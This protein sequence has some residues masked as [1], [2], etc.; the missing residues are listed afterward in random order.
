LEPDLS[1]MVIRWLSS[2]VLFFVRIE[3]SRWSPQD[4]LRILIDWK[5]K[6]LHLWNHI[7]EWTLDSIRYK[8]SKMSDR[9]QYGNLKNPSWNSYIM[10][11][12]ICAYLNLHI[13][14][15][16]FF[17]I[18]TIAWYVILS[19]VNSVNIQIPDPKDY[20][21]FIYVFLSSLGVPGLHA[22]SSVTETHTCRISI[23]FSETN[24]NQTCLEWS[25]DGSL[26]MF[27]FLWG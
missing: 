19:F 10:E 12:P 1:W 24:W 11:G 4:H 20:W 18:F 8:H 15:M 26:Q 21:L 7:V 22:T 25:S 5:F 17:D 14:I 9:V 6:N 3:R 2:D 23:F 27:C 13:R 16:K